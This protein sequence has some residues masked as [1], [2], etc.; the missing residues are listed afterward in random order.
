MNK[1]LNNLSNHQYVFFIFPSIF[2]PLYPKEVSKLMC[3]LSL[4]E[5]LLCPNIKQRVLGT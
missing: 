5:A 1:R 3:P 4:P 2:P